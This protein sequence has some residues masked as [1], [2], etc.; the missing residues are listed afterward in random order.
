[1]AAGAAIGALGA[2]GAKAIKTGDELATLATQYDTSAEAIQKFNYV[3][4]QTDVDADN[5]YKGL[6]KIRSGITDIAS[7]ATS[8]ASA[9]LQRLN[10]DFNALDGSEEQFYAIIDALASMENKTEMVDAVALK[11]ELPDVA[12]RYMVTVNTMRFTLS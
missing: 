4:L 11:N 5:L 3:A 1:M 10:I 6:V 9:A 7:G 2:M 8:A 12:A